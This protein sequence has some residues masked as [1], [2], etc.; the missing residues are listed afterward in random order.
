[1]ISVFHPQSEPDASV[2]ADHDPGEIVPEYQAFLAQQP[3]WQVRRRQVA[4]HPDP[5]VAEHQR[6]YGR[7]G[8]VGAQVGRRDRRGH[9]EREIDGLAELAW[10]AEFRLAVE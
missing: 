4:D 9:S 7:E 1:M 2:A 5:P 6:A 8:L 10:V 3:G